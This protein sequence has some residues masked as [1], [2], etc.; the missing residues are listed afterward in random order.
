MHNEKYDFPDSGRIGKSFRNPENPRRNGNPA[1]PRTAKR[2]F[3]QRPKQPDNMIYG[4]RPVIEAIKAGKEFEK[5]IVQKGLQSD[6]AKTLDGL[7]RQN[8]LHAQYVPLQRL[9]FLCSG[10][11]QGVV[12][13]LSLVEYA[14]IE[15]IVPAVFEA[16]KCPL[17]LIFDRITDV[18]NFGAMVRTAECAGVDAVIV[19]SQNTAALNE[20]AV[21]T[22]AGALLTVPLC[23]EDNLKSTIHFLKAS[24]IRVYAASEK[25]TIEYTDADL[26]MPTAFILGSEENGVSPEYLKLCDA[27]LR[28]PLLGKIDSLNVSV[29]NGIMLYEALRQRRKE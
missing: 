28:I 26:R 8:G 12:A 11:H 23:R 29:A 16:G 14:R 10:N 15:N 2:S 5:I 4:L 9:N 22:S 19:P 3:P 1:S 6:I 27:Q 13:Y 20:D 21:K 24:G 7:L 25:A 17:I 18:R